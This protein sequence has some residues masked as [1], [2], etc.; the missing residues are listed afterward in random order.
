MYTVHPYTHKPIRFDDRKSY[1]LSNS[2]KKDIIIEAISQL[3]LESM[4]DE[5]ERVEEGVILID[6]VIQN[7]QFHSSNGVYYFD[8]R[9]PVLHVTK[10]SEF[11]KR[12][13]LVLLEASKRSARPRLP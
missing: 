10:N 2:D 11:D 4:W 5:F 13:R 9:K 3:E 1:D 7:V 6:G 8:E 12:I